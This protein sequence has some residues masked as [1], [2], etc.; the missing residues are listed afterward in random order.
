M[1]TPTAG[2]SGELSYRSVHAGLNAQKFFAEDN[3][4]V[5]AGAFHFSDAV[6]PW[7]LTKS[8]FAGFKS[9]TTNSF[10]ASVSQLLSDKDLLLGGVSYTRQSGFLEGAR[11]T[12]S[13]GTVT[14]RAGEILPQGRDKF[15]A[16]TRYVHGLGGNLA[17][18]FDS[19][20]FEETTME[21]T[22]RKVRV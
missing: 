8:K 20:R 4:I 13:T 15:T 1:F 10:N 9:K 14:E 6:D 22:L 11:N 17:F 18:H 19:L 16:N 12:V 21:E 3:F 2:Y 5:S 7:D